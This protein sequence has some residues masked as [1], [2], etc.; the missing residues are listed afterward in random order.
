[1]VAV[2][3]ELLHLTGTERVLEIGTGSGYQTAV[4]AELAG[5]VVSVERYAELSREAA[6]L[7]GELGC[8][9]VT[10]IVGDGTLGHPQRAPYD[11]ILVT[12]A[13]VQVP[14]PLGEQL[15]E[16]G[17]LVIPVGG[18]DQQTLQVLNK[19]AGQSEGIQHVPCRF[20]P[21]IGV[22]GWPES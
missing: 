14:G 22:H 11:R 19:A 7:L 4:L 13:A 5:E 15:A 20:V 2:M 21:L 12:A 3:T 8:R 9:K 17:I 18:R 1:M 16:G 10:L 6:R